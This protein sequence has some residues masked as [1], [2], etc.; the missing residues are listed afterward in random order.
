[1]KQ[2]YLLPYHVT[3]NKLKKKIYPKNSLEIESNDELK[4]INIKNCSY[5]YFDDIIKIEDFD[6]D[7]I[8]LNEKSYKHILV[9]KI[10]YNTLIGGKPLYIRF[11]KVDGLIR[12]YNGKRYLALIRHEKYDV[13]YNRIRYLLSQKNG[14]TYVVSHSY[15][16]IKVDSYNS[17]R[18]EETLAFYN[19]IIL[20]KTI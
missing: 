7:D 11:D 14:I 15:A 19:I 12:V 2:K 20:I 13:I 8:L 17:L 16:R 18:L 5:H 4:E 1:M 9:Y 6:F 10:L 3:N